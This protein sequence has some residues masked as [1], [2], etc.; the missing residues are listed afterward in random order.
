MV[1]CYSR[2]CT[3]NLVKNC[4]SFDNCD[5]GRNDADGFAAKLTCGNGNKFYGCISHHNIDDGWDLYAKSVSG[6]IGLVTIENCVAYNNGWLTTD[7]ITDANYEYGEGNGFKLGGGYLKGGHVL[8][9]SITFDNH[10]KG[11]TSNSCPD[12]KI[13]DCTSYNNSINNSAY[14]VGLNTKDSNKKEWVVNGLISINN[15]KNTK[16]E[17]LIPFALH[18]ENN[19]IYNGSAS[20]NSNGV[21]A[22][23]DW[24]V[25]VDTSV[26]PTRNEDGTINMHGVLEL[27]ESAPANSGARLDVTSADAISVQ[28][29]TV[30][31]GKIEIADTVEKADTPAVKTELE[32]TDVLTPAEWEAY[33]GGADVKVTLDV[34]NADE[35]VSDTDKKL[36][37]DKVAEA[38][39]DGVVGQ[40][41]D[42][43]I[44]K[45]VG[46]TTTEVTE[47]NHP[48]AVSVTVPEKLIN[49]DS[50]KTREYSIIRLHNGVAE[51]LEGAKT[52]TVDGKLVISFSTDK[53]STYVIVYK[54]TVNR[55]PGSDDGNKGD[56]NTPSTPD[57]PTEPTKPEKPVKPTNPTEPVTPTEPT[58]PAEPST[59][60]VTG[61]TDAATDNGAASNTDSTTAAATESGEST[62]TGDMAHTAVYAVLAMVAAGLAL[63]VVVYDNKKKRI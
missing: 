38:V 44:N 13:Y 2:F 14:N 9:N 11:I 57:K 32:V 12:I 30:A 7:D 58:K 53:F 46:E 34:N 21:E 28:P 25:S 26:L 39:K 55:N 10:A 35:T 1:C 45:T 41:V 4:E 47:T 63:A 42:I 3:D 54:D 19:Y 36:V 29:S 20:Y 33:K 37:E 40:Y 5:A 18:S 22:T 59:G 23:D 43:S 24:F 61:N 49:T 15:E 27:N 6:E 60:D 31:P 48:I 56:D 16:L 51:V 50:T 52:E 8:K 62:A 17:D